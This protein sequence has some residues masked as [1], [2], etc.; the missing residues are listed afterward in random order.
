MND[1]E[2]IVAFNFH[3]LL[4]CGILATNLQY[5]CIQKRKN[6]LS[7]LKY[8]AN[9]SADYSRNATI[10]DVITLCMIYMGKWID[11]KRIIIKVYI[12]LRF[13]FITV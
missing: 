6:L 5:I 8:N 9:V 12:L 4:H 11:S 13:I 3:Y 10:Y 7:S 2:I 1:S